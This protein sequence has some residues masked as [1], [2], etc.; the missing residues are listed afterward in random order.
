MSSSRRDLIVGIFILV[1]LSAI[2]VLS[3]KV[4]GLS[5][6][7]AGGLA[8]VAHFDQVGGLSVRAPVVI[9][10]VKVGQV[11]AIEL[12]E[13]LRARVRIDVDASLAL[14]VD[15]LAGIRTAGL[16]GDQFVALQP[17]GDDRLL[18]A[19]DV[20][21]FTESALSLEKLIGSLVQDSGVVSGS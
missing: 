17:G 2:A 8:L 10:G 18:R 14:P 9:A 12:D 16:L 7:G 6:T 1:G 13:D 3:V 21:D 19:G 20:I 4:G 5:Y 15:T 11:T